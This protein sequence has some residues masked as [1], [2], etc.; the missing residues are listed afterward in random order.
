MRL[1]Y[2]ALR[3]I[4]LLMAKSNALRQKL[5]RERQQT[6]CAAAFRLKHANEMRRHRLLRSTKQIKQDKA[7]ARN[8][9]RC[10]RAARFWTKNNKTTKVCDNE[11]FPSSSSKQPYQSSSTLGKAVKKVQRALPQSPT[12]SITVVNHLVVKMGFPPIKTLSTATPI[13]QIT[14]VEQKVADFYHRDDVS[15]QSPVAKDVVV[16]RNVD[17]KTKLSKRHMLMKLREAYSMFVEE[18]G[19]KEVCFSRFCN[20]RPVDVLLNSEMPLDVCL[21]KVHENFISLVYALF[22]SLTYCSSWITD[23]VICKKDELDAI[24]LKGA[25]V[26]CNKGQN[27]IHLSAAGD[28]VNLSRWQSESSEKR[29][30]KVKLTLQHSDA[31]ANF[32]DL[33]PHFLRHQYI[34]RNQEKMYRLDKASESKDRLVIQIDFAENYTCFHQAEIQAA[35]WHQ[36][37]ITLFTACCWWNLRMDSFVVVS[38]S[39]VHDKITAI[40]YLV[41]VLDKILLKYSI[42]NIKEISVWSD[43][44]AR[45]LKI[46]I[47]CTFCLNYAPGMIAL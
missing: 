10:L 1:A 30:Q 27:V 40:S 44:P 22:P 47:L 38:D 7:N 18:V 39:I 17:G 31:V 26:N 29:L 42:R 41:N 12:K 34:K 8:R 11:S 23:H 24:C 6:L 3:C 43:G 28:E 9:M 15:R 16:C 37:Q 46:A 32:V 5:W 33:L 20:L 21:C 35:H 36:Q 4:C 19:K 13:Q 45:N 25:C 2:F 14:A